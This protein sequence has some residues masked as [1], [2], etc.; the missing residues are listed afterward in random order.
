MLITTEDCNGTSESLSVEAPKLSDAI[1]IHLGEHLR[2]TYAASMQASPPPHLGDLLARLE[3]LLADAKG[4]DDSAFRAGLLEAATSLHSF[5]ISLTRNP[6]A[7]DDLVQDTMLRAWRSRGSFKVGTNLGAWLFTIMRNA[8]YSVHRKH[9]RE[10]ADSDGDHAARLTSLPEQGG[11]LDLQDVQAA[12][13][14]LSPPMREAL[15]LVAVEN[16]SY[17]EAAAILKCRIGTVKSRVWRAR[18]QLAHMLGYTGAEVGADHL[19]LSA[20]GESAVGVGA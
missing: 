12:L 2:T 17:E 5:A 6:S 15:I 14:R 1:R 13:G 16:V 4:R 8:F 10:V 9:A 20:I 19:T 7:A 11:H 18:D 3:A